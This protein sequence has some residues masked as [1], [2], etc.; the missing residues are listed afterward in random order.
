MLDHLKSVLADKPVSVKKSMSRKHQCANF[1]LY[2]EFKI[3]ISNK[4]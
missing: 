4:K 1:K 2:K 3:I